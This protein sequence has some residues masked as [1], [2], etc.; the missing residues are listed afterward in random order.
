MIPG[1]A[2]HS[3]VRQSGFKRSS[4]KSVSA[5]ARSPVRSWNELYNM[6]CYA[7]ADEPELARS[8]IITK[9]T[10][11]HQNAIIASESFYVNI[12]LHIYFSSDPIPTL[13]KSHSVLRQSYREKLWHLYPSRLYRSLLAKLHES[14]SVHSVSLRQSRDELRSLCLTCIYRPAF[15]QTGSLRVAR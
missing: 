12:S 8:I 7:E 15:G 10:T 14:Q 4:S 5:M 3:Y 9:F 6:I 1:R 13:W 11:S 2:I